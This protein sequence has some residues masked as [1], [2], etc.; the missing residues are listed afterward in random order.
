MSFSYPHGP[1]GEILWN[2][3]Y[4]LINILSLAIFAQA[5]LSWIV[6]RGVPRLSA[7]L[8]D[9][10]QPILAPIRRTIPPFGMMDLSPLIAILL[11]QFI[12]LRLL[13]GITSL[14]A[15]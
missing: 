1:L 15:A 10:T 4:I 8:Y 3:E 9:L 5:I 7:L 11:L 2:A 14:I 12:V 6:P 13:W